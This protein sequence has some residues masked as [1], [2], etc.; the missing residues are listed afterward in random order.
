[1]KRR[2][3]CAAW[4]GMALAGNALADESGAYV[5][6]ALGRAEMR[7]ESRLGGPLAVDEDKDDSSWTL[8]LGLRF[9]RY[10][11]V[12]LGYVD[13]GEASVYLS[14]PD[15][16]FYSGHRSIAVEGK[17]LALVGMLPIGQCETYVKAGM[18]FAKT[19]ARFDGQLL[20]Y[21][22]TY[23]L[24]R[25]SEDPFYGAGLRYPAREPFQV[26]LDVTYFDEVGDNTTGS[27]SY[28]NTSAGVLW[29]F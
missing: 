14:M 20:D 13:L 3:L 22:L 27:S 21:S 2:F 16:S 6:A 23:R 5:S 9:N 28:L 19:D 1:M 4:V 18:L 26:Y 8:G 10:L 12:D 11:A 24:R 15:R 25:D 7:S 29:Q 17:T